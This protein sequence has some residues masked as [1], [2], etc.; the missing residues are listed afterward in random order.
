MAPMHAGRGQMRLA[1][2]RSSMENI[3]APLS[4]VTPIL[5]W[6]ASIF[7][8][9]EMHDDSD[10]DQEQH[11]ADIKDD[12]RDS[13]GDNIKDILGNTLR[14]PK[15]TMQSEIASMQKILYEQWEMLNNAI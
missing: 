7:L 9:D 6:Q 13:L 12:L 15:P 14:K 5:T 8:G 11:T 1:G 3:W 10:H 2:T 4:L